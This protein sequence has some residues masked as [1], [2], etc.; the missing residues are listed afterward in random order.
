[1]K[2]AG[3]SYVYRLKYI[4]QRLEWAGL[5]ESQ[6]DA[7]IEAI[8]KKR[9]LDRYDLKSGGSLIKLSDLNE[10]LN[11][12]GFDLEIGEEDEDDYDD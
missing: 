4:H 9:I 7:V 6:I 12:L 10:V 2:E 8:I 1:L 3:D 5:D 11:D